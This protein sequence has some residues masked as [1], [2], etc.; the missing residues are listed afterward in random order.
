M[1]PLR[2][3]IILNLVLLWVMGAICIFWPNLVA[4]SDVFWIFFPLH[5]AVWGAIGPALCFRAWAP[6]ASP[7]S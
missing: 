1:T 5:A 7:P 2:I 4:E 3:T 6:A